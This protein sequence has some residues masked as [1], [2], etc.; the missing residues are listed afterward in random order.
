I[1]AGAAWWVARRPARPN[2]GTWG[3]WIGLCLGAALLPGG[4]LWAAALAGLAWRLATTALERA[5]GRP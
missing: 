2:P 1:G 5:R 3:Y 4:A